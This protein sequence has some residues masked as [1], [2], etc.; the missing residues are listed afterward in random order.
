MEFPQYRKYKNDHSYF[1]I[2]S[3]TKF[4][5]YKTLGSKIEK[6]NFEATILPDRNFI[7]DMLNDYSKHWDKINRSEFEG[8]ISKF[9][10]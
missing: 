7:H 8:F 4:T 10:L 2:I 9:T 1:K 5:E 6:F 3:A